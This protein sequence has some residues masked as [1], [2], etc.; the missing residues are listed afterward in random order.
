M[1]TQEGAVG[2]LRFLLLCVV[3]AVDPDDG[4][5][6][7]YAVLLSGGGVR[8]EVSQTAGGSVQ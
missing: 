6:A 5:V 2:M 4:E 8:P 3:R 1:K 7:V